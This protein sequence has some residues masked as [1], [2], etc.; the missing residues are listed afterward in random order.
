MKYKTKERL[1]K[2]N[3]EANLRKGR[4]NESVEIVITMF[5]EVVNFAIELVTE[6]LPFVFFPCCLSIFF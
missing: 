5:K 1:L 2:T 3:E 4:K 6:Y